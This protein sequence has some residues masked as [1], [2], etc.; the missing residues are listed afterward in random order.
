M[1]TGQANGRTIASPLA[2]KLAEE[3]GINIS[4]LKGTGEGGRIVKR[5]MKKSKEFQV[6]F[7]ALNKKGEYGGYSL[8]KG[9]NYAVCYSDS[10]NF[11]V[12]AKSWF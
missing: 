2:K 11:L 6:G 5:D 8:Q 4:N 12:D 7:I 3:K 1:P 9:F 10:K